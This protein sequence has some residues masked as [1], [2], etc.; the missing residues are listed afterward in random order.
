MAAAADARQTLAVHISAAAG[1]LFARGVG[2]GEPRVHTVL[3][4][5]SVTVVFD[6]HELAPV[7]VDEGGRVPGRERLREELMGLVERL[8][9]QPV[10]GFLFEY[11][12]EE[13]KVICVFLLRGGPSTT[14][15]TS[16]AL[17]LRRP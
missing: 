7:P 16:C 8:C 6:A 4:D 13:R 2:I 15:A 9:K 17:P 12:G 10:D 11:V 3:D 5:R 1:R 14:P